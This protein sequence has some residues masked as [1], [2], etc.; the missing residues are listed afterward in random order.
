MLV[1]H[2]VREGVIDEMSACG[3]QPHDTATAVGSTGSPFN[4]TARLQPVKTLTHRT[5]GHHG[6]LRELTRHS[7]ERSTGAP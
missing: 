2:M 7:L 5:G 6:E 4:Q 3:G 1:A